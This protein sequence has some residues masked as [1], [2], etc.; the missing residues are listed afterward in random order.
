MY[1]Y[2]GVLLGFENTQSNGIQKVFQMDWLK[3]QGFVKNA[4][5]WIKKLKEKQSR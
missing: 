3:N 5:E 2:W 4:K 1:C